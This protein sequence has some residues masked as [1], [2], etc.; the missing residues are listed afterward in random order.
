MAKPKKAA[1][2]PKPQDDELRVQADHGDEVELY[3]G[4]RITR[5]ELEA[6]KEAQADKEDA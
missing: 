5:D 2:A 6:R 3:D 4:S 1:P